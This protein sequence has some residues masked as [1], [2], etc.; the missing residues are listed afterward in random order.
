[1]GGMLD[2]GDMPSC[3]D[4]ER[5]MLENVRLEGRLEYNR[6]H[7]LVFQ[8]FSGGKSLPL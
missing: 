7:V 3:T 2:T 6:G 5:Q 4:S 8:Y 1:M